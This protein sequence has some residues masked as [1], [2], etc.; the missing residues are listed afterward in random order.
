MVV[1]ILI[2]NETFYEKGYAKINLHLDVV[3]KNVDGYHNIRSIMQTVSLCDEIS[4]SLNSENRDTLTSNVTDMPTD[5]NNIAMK[6]VKV[7]RDFTGFKFG[8]DIH[9]E[10]NIPLAA[11]LAG[12]SADAAAV[13]KLLLRATEKDLSNEEITSLATRLGADVPFC[14]FGGTCLAEG[15]GER[16]CAL[17]AC[18]EI[19]C[20]IAI[21]GERVSTPWAYSE[22]DKTYTDFRDGKIHGEEIFTAL[23]SA[24]HSQD[25]RN[26]CNSIYNIFEEGIIPHR[27]EVANIKRIMLENGALS[28][29]MSG[30]GPSVFGFFENET[31]ARKAATALENV[32]AEAFVCRT[33]QNVFI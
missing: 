27:P 21:K 11:G 14:Y 1:I 33:I 6:A 16:L 4:L 19:D 20:V 18:P 10:K 29:V 12:G 22:L 28:S 31:D 7:F 5:E 15:R 3:A 9:I 26:V 17:P 13:L 24:L 8:V 30:S 32:G 25:K 23:T 2:F